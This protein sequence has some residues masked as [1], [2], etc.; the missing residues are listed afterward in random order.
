MILWRGG[1]LLCL[2]GL[3]GCG[4]PHHGRQALS[5]TVHFRGELLAQGTIQFVSV[6]RTPQ[7]S[8]GAAIINGRYQI[9]AE[10]GLPP[11]QYQVLISCPVRPAGI[12]PDQDYLGLYD[13][14]LPTAV[15]S[16]TTL[17]AEVTA[18]GP[19]RFDFPIAAP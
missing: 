3:V 9:P 14:L 2:A 16:A 7:E 13:E 17:R 6:E 4:E 11:G 10:Q 1:F 19:N 8:S 5:G 18:S 15:N 12:P